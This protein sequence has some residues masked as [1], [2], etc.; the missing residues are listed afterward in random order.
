MEKKKNML[1][2]F[3]MVGGGGGGELYHELN[4]FSFRSKCAGFDISEC[5]AWILTW[6]IKVVEKIF[7]K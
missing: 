6:L 5:Q 4:F 7:W 1:D 2:F 3:N